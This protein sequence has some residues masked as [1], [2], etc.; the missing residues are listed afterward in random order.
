MRNWWIRFGCF[1]TGYNHAIVRQSSE[2][3]AKAVKRYTSAI[4]I[5][6]II[7]S[8]IGYTFTQRYLH[9][10]LTGSII[11]SVVLVIIIVQIERQIVLSVNPTKWLYLSR[12]V[13]AIMMAIIGTIIIDQIIFK[14]D[15]ELEKIT[16]IQ[17]RVDKALPPKTKELE[18]QIAK[19]DT[20]IVNKEHER[21]VLMEDIKRN[22]TTTVY[23][24]SPSPKIVRKTTI[25]TLTGKPI[26]TENIV[27][28]T[29]TTRTDIP[30]PNIEHVKPMEQDIVLLRNQ[31]ADKEK[32]LLDIR[33]RLEK[34]IS[35]KVGF[36]DELEV[37][38]QLIT[39]SNVALVV[40][41]I[42]F[43]FLFG[44]EMIVLISKINEKENDYDKTVVHQMTLQNK[45]LDALARITEKG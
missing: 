15:I 5:V 21:L 30:N 16:F 26:T 3:S 2:V 32:I 27:P 36:L 10:G 41:F 8:F 38:Y 17:N 7:W 22:P 4:L 31:K 42:W 20:A 14:E 11:G 37:M 35:S 18:L 19:L 12:G 13:I 40:W 29:V 45:R 24:T 43:L 39:H 33:P 34:E 9:G 44:L 23:S 25:D 28:G 6:C 1:L